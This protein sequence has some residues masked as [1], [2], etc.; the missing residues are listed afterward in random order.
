MRALVEPLRAIPLLKVT[1]G[2]SL[3]V[4]LAMELHLSWCW[5]LLVAPAAVL[6]MVRGYRSSRY[7]RRWVYGLGAVL[8][9]FSMGGCYTALRQQQRVA[10]PCDQRAFLTVCV[11]D[12]PVRTRYGCR[13]TSKV[14]AAP[15]SL[16]TLVGSR[17]I[18]YCSSSSMPRY[19]SV[20]RLRA[21]VKPIDPPKNPY[22]FSFSDY[23]ARQG[24]FSSLFVDDGAFMQVGEARVSPLLRAAYFLQRYTLQTFVRLGFQGD[25][26]GVILALMIGDKQ[27]LDGHLKTMYANVG[28]MHILAVSGMHVALYYMV[29]AGLLFFMRGRVG[30]VAKNIVILVALW[31]F[32]FVAGFA[33]SIVRATV[34]FSFILFGRMVG[35]GY[36]TYNM[37]AASFLVLLLYNPFSLYDVGFLL[38]YAAVFSI[39]LFYPFFEK[40]APTNVVLRWGYDLVAVSLA[41]QVLT[42]PLTVYF[43]HQFPLVFLL[44]NI[45]LIPL[46]TLIIYGG[47][48]LLS[49]AWWTWGAKVVAVVLVFLL[50]LTN[51]SVHVIEEMPGAVLSS[52]A[53]SRWQMLLLF[54]SFMLMVIFA[55]YRK[56]RVL[57]VSLVLMAT[58]AAGS[59]FTRMQERSPMLVV[60]SM[61]KA[62]AVVLSDGDRSYCLCDSIRDSYSYRFMDQSLIRWGRRASNELRYVCFKDSLGE[63]DCK[64]CRGWCSYMGRSIVF[65]SGV[66][67]RKTSAAPPVEVDY[68]VVCGR[69]KGRPSELL[70]Y[71]RP[72]LVVVDG[73]ASKY[74][75]EKWK[76]ACAHEHIPCFSVVDR[77]AFVDYL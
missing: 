59:A 28:A 10:L 66:V 54:T 57:I 71:V 2:F 27:L 33:P 68:L 73:S 9:F 26:L 5:V 21:W 62:T 47:M 44:T 52:I 53:F 48:L 34:M 8:L 19:A 51:Q 67:P 23:Y 1:V 63:A 13:W 37:I 17:S 72:H 32:A 11:D 43:F 12:N 58:V 25:E 69:S 65:W 56:G 41:A 15:D 31:L 40:W 38:S 61:R 60:Y 14:V 75:S 24:V 22:E 4:A 46:T 76:K 45:I 77:G 39:L 6:L 70:K 7:G 30:G 50:K 42:L 16:R 20:L 64:C 3:G 36:N 49:I 35:R 55:L 29:L 18:T 74:L